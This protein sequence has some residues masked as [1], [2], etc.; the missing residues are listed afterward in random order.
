MGHK[1][2]TKIGLFVSL[3]CEIFDLVFYLIEPCYAGCF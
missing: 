3:W 1:W 2:G